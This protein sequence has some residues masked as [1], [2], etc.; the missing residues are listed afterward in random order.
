MP[1]RLELCNENIDFD[2]LTTDPARESRRHWANSMRTLTVFLAGSGARQRHT[3]SIRGQEW[4]EIDLG[5][6]VPG[7]KQGQRGCSLY[8]IRYMLRPP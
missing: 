1:G 4:L 2:T 5:D 6:F 8:E 7:G 3:A